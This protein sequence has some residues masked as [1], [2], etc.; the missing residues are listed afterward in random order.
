MVNND[1][2][3]NDHNLIWF[4]LGANT[5]NWFKPKAWEKTLQGIMKGQ[6]AAA[7]QP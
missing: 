6:P 5:F 2:I 3:I 7:R 4:E 1:N